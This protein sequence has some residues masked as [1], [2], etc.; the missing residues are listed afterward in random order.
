MSYTLQH[1]HQFF[2]ERM[3]GTL[4][5]QIFHLI[6]GIEK[7][8][9][10]TACN[11]LR[12]SSLLIMAFIFAYQVNPVFLL[13]L[14]IWRFAFIG[15]SLYM[16]RK[17]VTLSQDQAVQESVLGG[18]IIDS[19]THAFSVTLFA[20]R[21]QEINR[22]DTS[23]SNYRKVYQKKELYILIMNSIQGALIA[24]MMAFSTYF[25][26]HLYIRDLVTIGDFALILGLSMETGHMT[27]YTM[28][29]VDE[30]NKTLGRCK[31]S[32]DSLM[33]PLEIK[34]K[35]N[36]ITLKCDYGQIIFEKVKFHYKGTEPLFE[37]KSIE[38]KAGQKI[39]LVGYSGGGK[40]TFVNLILRLYDVTDGT[41]LID[42]QDIRDVTQD[43]LRANIA[44]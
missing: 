4:S 35:P 2:Q 37:N 7:I 43:S 36:A 12:A 10:S 32:L 14:V 17:L 31:Q 29:V 19:L 15:I 21:G 40:S 20:R 26:V 11:L 42:G 23:F 8:I 28:S 33:I 9:A 22:R 13:I 38:I 5:K 3:A 18:Q 6:D 1:S 34:D 24:I 25:L 39:G 30:F 16:S 41:I 44:K 27:W